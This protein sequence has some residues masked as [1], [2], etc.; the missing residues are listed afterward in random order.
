MWRLL[1]GLF[2]V[3]HGFVHPWL[4]AFPRANNTPPQGDSWLLHGLFGMGSSDHTITAVV[5]WTATAA[6]ILAGLLV[7]FG[8]KAG[9]RLPSRGPS[10][11]PLRSASFSSLG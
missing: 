2:L 7:W 9:N 11:E 10:R 6:L 1:L 4:W 5:A 8:T 3:A